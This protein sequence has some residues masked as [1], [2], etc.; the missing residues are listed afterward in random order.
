VEPDIEESLACLS[1]D[2]VC[3]PKTNH[4]KEDNMHSMV[5]EDIQCDHGCTCLILH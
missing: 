5:E 3:N 2:P 4:I 1:A